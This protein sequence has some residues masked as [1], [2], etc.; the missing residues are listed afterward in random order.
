MKKTLA[1]FSGSSNPELAD[2][3]AEAEQR[4]HRLVHA[5]PA[6]VK[7]HFTRFFGF[8][9]RTLVRFLANLQCTLIALQLG[10]E[11]AMIWRPRHHLMEMRVV[12]AETQSRNIVQFLQYRQ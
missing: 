1:L 7:D 12:N 3:I 5:E 10:T 4:R 9:K 2:Q 11:A 8:L 6:P